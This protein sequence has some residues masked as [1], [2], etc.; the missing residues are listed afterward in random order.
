MSRTLSRLSGW[1][2]VAGRSATWRPPD[3]WVTGSGFDMIGSRWAWPRVMDRKCQRITR[4]H[5]WPSGGA[6]HGRPA[7][8]RTVAIWPQWHIVVLYARRRSARE[9]GNDDPRPAGRSRRALQGARGTD[10]AADPAAASAWR[11]HR[12]R[13]GRDDRPEAGQRVE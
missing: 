2:S 9:Q 3:F 5:D 8:A 1:G 12:D 4:S 10:A 6:G 7:L 13:A 11:A